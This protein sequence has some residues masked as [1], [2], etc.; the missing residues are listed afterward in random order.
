MGLLG[1]L[2]G[3]WLER[4]ALSGERALWRLSLRGTQLEVCDFPSSIVAEAVFRELDRDELKLRRLSLPPGARI[5]DI[6]SQVGIVSIYLAKRFPGC[7]ILAFEPYRPSY[8]LL[9]ENLRRN[10]VAEVEPRCLAVTGDGRPFAMVGNTGVN[11]GGTTGCSV[12]LERGQANFEAPST[13]LDAILEELG[14]CELLKIDCEGA[15]HE[16]LA[17]SRRLAEAGRL[18]GEFHRN[19]YLERRGRDPD[20]LEALAKARLGGRVV[21]KKLRMCD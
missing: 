16:I 7:R 9:V 5:I 13:T 11:P 12:A 14:G 8:E 15:E 6:G 20:R 2:R 1:R 17:S 4:R 10:G 18:V 19:A 21:V 3:S